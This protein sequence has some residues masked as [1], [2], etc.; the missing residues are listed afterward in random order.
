MEPLNKQS[1][2][3][4]ARNQLETARVASSGRSATTLYGGHEQVLRQTMI[5]LAAGSRMDDHNNPGEATLYVVSG[6]VRLMSDGVSWDGMTG[7]LLIIPQA[8][9]AVEALEDSAVLLTVA[10]HR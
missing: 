2:T 7:D 8:V 9:H 4:V 5:A 6:R 10:K 3:A 1:L